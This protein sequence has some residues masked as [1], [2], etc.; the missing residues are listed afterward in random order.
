MRRH[1][2]WRHRGQVGLH[3]LSIDHITRA[4]V[5]DQK[6]CLDR[7]YYRWRIEMNWPKGGVIAFAASDYS[8]ELRATP[9]RSKQPRLPKALR[10]LG[11]G[12]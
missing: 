12:A 10:A 1:R 2:L 8:L 6:V 7:P 5:A 9:I 4:P 3:E 11:Q